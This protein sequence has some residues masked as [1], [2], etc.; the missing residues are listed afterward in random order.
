MGAAIIPFESESNAGAFL[1]VSA[2]VGEP[3]RARKDGQETTGE[4]P[5]RERKAPDMEEFDI[6]TGSRARKQS[7]AP[8]VLD[9]DVEDLPDL[10]QQSAEQEQDV[11]QAAD[12][13]L[14]APAADLDTAIRQFMLGEGPQLG[15]NDIQRLDDAAHKDPLLDTHGHLA[16]VD[17]GYNFLYGWA[18]GRDILAHIACMVHGSVAAAH[19]AGMYRQSD[20]A[21]EAEA[22]PLQ[23]LEYGFL[24]RG[25][26]TEAKIAH[27]TSVLRGLLRDSELKKSVV[28]HL[29]RNTLAATLLSEDISSYQTATLMGWSL[30]DQMQRSYASKTSVSSLPALE[31]GAGFAPGEVYSVPRSTVDPLQ[32][33][34]GVYKLFV[35][36]WMVQ[37]REQVAAG[38]AE[39]GVEW[40]GARDYLLAREHMMRVLL[41]NLPFYVYEYGPYWALFRL[42]VFWAIAGHENGG[43]AAAAANHPLL[44]EFQGFAKDV[45]LAHYGQHTLAELL[46]L[47]KSMM[48][49][50][51]FPV[52][53]PLLAANLPFADDDAKV[54]GAAFV[55]CVKSAYIEAIDALLKMPARASQCLVEASGSGSGEEQLKVVAEMREELIQSQR[56]VIELQQQLLQQ[57]GPMA[58]LGPWYGGLVPPGMWPPVGY[59]P[60]PRGVA[61]AA[62]P[63]Q[64]TA[65]LGGSGLSRLL[66]SLESL[67]SSSFQAL[68]ARWPAVQQAMASAGS[69]LSGR[70]KEK[71]LRAYSLWQR[72]FNCVGSF[73]DGWQDQQVVEIMDSFRAS[74]RPASRK[75]PMPMKR[76]LEGVSYALRCRE[77]TKGVGG[78][79]IGGESS[80][81]GTN[82]EFEAAFAAAVSRFANEKGMNAPAF[83]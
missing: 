5:R 32:L 71:A 46:L 76:F 67:E 64:E 12:A 63:A 39:N 75:S 68:H 21:V 50:S 48:D 81:C 9:A 56:H 49:G 20:P 28:G 25:K 26:A 83:F 77:S 31:A 57:R 2:G 11:L 14:P 70:E 62:E 78:T 24:A 73:F 1:P 35:P 65:V 17:L 69:A 47:Q 18:Q 16:F 55:R 45:L 7:K 80:H 33:C 44:D 59:A 36:D 6:T 29:G 3:P 74:Y 4:R 22:K 38:I 66:M 41:Q 53:C 19:A 34:P 61:A 30:G 40:E 23:W 43:W 8:P 60:A 51:S 42:Q 37:L 10:P 82:A 54:C 52:P 27:V 58:A 15:V 79:F 13:D 72:V